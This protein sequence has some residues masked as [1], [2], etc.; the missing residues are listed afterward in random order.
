MGRSVAIKWGKNNIIF[1]TSC[2]AR[3]TKSRINLKR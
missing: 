2:P 1:A 3:H